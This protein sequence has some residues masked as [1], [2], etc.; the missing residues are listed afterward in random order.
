M[1]SDR[2]WNGRESGEI[3]RH[4]TVVYIFTSF[5]EYSRANGKVCSVLRVFYYV[6]EG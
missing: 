4:D 1:F 3:F 5:Y 6:P 2:F